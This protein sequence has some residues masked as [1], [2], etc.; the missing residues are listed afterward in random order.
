MHARLSPDDEQRGEVASIDEAV[1]V[2]VGRA[3]GARP[4]SDEHLGEVGARHDAVLIEVGV[5][6]RLRVGGHRRGKQGK[7]GDGRGKRADRAAKAKTE[8]RTGRE[9]G[10]H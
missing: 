5:A 10:L 2:D 7:R 9:R 6:G 1:A 3:A 8:I 4:P